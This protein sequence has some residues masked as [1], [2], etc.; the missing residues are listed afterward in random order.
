MAALATALSLPA[1]SAHANDLGTWLNADRTA[2]LELRECGAKGLC[3]EIVWLKDPLDEKGKP[4]RDI[5]N[6]NTVKRGRPIIGIDVLEGLKKVD[7]KTWSG[8]IY[9]PEE[10]KL[11]YLKFIKVHRDK[12]EI[13]GCLSSGWPCRTKYWTRTAPVRAPEPPIQVAKP[14]PAQQQPARQAVAA[15]PAAP[16][17]LTPPAARAT[18]PQ[19][20]PSVQQ[21]AQRQAAAQPVRPAPQ[22]THVPQPLPRPRVQQ[23]VQRQAAAQPAQPVAP[24]APRSALAAAASPITT[25]AVPRPATVAPVRASTRYLVQVT[26]G[27]NQNEALTTFGKLQRRYPNLLGGYLPNIQKVDLGAKGIWYRVR[28]GPVGQHIVAVGFCNKLKAAGADCL[29]RQE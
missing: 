22:A 8:Q 12:V 19:P 7:Q 21:P 28:V 24:R 4:W 27:Q 18:P 3:S 16:A 9:D 17:P 2:K 6:Q 10:G 14:R 23:P 25:G 5:L 29:I 20:R 15:M 1:G 13:R 26:A 11:Y